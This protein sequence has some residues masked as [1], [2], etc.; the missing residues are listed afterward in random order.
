MSHPVFEGQC[1]SSASDGRRCA[2]A[3]VRR[4][5]QA[6][7]PPALTDNEP[8]HAR[9]APYLQWYGPPNCRDHCVDLE[10]ARDLIVQDGRHIAARAHELRAEVNVH[11][12]FL[13]LARQY[14]LGDQ[15][16]V[17]IEVVIPFYKKHLALSQ[18]Q[19]PCQLSACKSCSYNEDATANL[20]QMQE[21]VA[22]AYNG[23]LSLP[24]KGFERVPRSARP[25]AR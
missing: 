17:L 5:E 21:G 2:V 19:R 24:G 12:A 14:K 7:G 11:P 4:I 23:N 3:A 8:Q 1:S 22:G 25:R 20:V 9:P 16:N 18:R 6:A 15:V 13:E 10:F